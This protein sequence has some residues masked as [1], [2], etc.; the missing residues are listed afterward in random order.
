MDSS[1]MRLI[2]GPRD[3]EVIGRADSRFVEV[4]EGPRHDRQMHVYEV[5]GRY[6]MYLGLKNEG[7]KE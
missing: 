3:M 1:E 5:R 7:V 2:G 6:A 4:P